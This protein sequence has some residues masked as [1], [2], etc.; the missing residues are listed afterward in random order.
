MHRILHHNLCHQEGIPHHL[1]YKGEV[2]EHYNLESLEQLK[3]KRQLRNVVLQKRRGGGMCL[4][5]VCIII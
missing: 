5:V 2:E 3:E 4:R 1:F